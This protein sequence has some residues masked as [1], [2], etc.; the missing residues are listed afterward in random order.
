MIRT[1][2][3]S[4]TIKSVG[5]DA[6]SKT[7]EVEFGSGRYRYADVPP[8][9]HTGLVGAESAGKYFAANVRAKFQGQKLEPEQ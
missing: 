8:E 1:P 7:M 3:K 9:V 5:Y 6:E 4:S 2:I